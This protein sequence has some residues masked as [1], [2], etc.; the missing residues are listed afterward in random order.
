VSTTVRG[1]FALTVTGASGTI[2]HQATV[3]LTVR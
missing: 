1:T 2:Q 3:T